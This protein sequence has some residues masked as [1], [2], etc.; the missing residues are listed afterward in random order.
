M[1]QDL[2]LAAFLDGT[3][4][5]ARRREVEKAIDDTPAVR[6][7]LERLR[8]AQA[9]LRELPPARPDL[10]ARVLDDVE[11]PP[12]PLW[13]RWSVTAPTA[14]AAAAVLVALVRP[15][16]FSPRGGATTGAA[17]VAVVV[18]GGHPQHPLTR[19]EQLSPPPRLSVDVNALPA[20]AP[21]AIAVWATDSA[22]A[23]TWLRPTWTDPLHP[24]PCERLS[25]QAS[26]SPATTGVEFNAPAGPLRISF[27]VRA[28]DACDLPGLDDKLETGE[29]VDDAIDAV[30]VVIVAANA[31]E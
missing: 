11:R 9:R 18:R 14:A 25:A 10:A 23:V 22:G 28:P 24:P 20:D 17:N 31:D 13:R 7:E 4:D 21:R 5:E 26:S 12:R 3:L 27:V 16:P 6:D 29:V 8:A 30:D 15:S 19:R 1:S 2:D